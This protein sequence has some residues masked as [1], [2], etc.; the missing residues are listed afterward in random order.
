MMREKTKGATR[1][2]QGP[3]FRMGVGSGN[4]SKEE[5]T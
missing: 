1:E 3:Y 5:D 4:A 2:Y